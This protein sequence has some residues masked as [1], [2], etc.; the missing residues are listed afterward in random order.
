MH[1]LS[2]NLFQNTNSLSNNIFNFLYK[3]FFF[4]N[5]NNYT[6]YLK[7]GY[8]KIGCIDDKYITDIIS[9]LNVQAKNI[10]AP[11]FKLKKSRNTIISIK[12]IINNCL[13]D[14]LKNLENIFNASIKFSFSEITRNYHVDTKKEYYS[15]YLHTDG[16]NCLLQKIFIN[17]D[18]VNENQGPLNILKYPISKKTKKKL[19]ENNYRLHDDKIKIDEELFFI[20]TGKK[21]S[22]LI[23]DST[24]VLHKAGIPKKNNHRDMLLLEF[25][26]VPKDNANSFYLDENKNDLDF[27][28]RDD[29][30]FSKSEA[31]LKSKFEL[32]KK[33]LKIII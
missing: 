10:D 16:Y 14:H 21:G 11:N 28:L 27:Y 29:N 26:I 19:I 23:V 22:V 1:K 4:K 13:K 32:I 3:K 24:N 15:N 20:N 31:K 25:V 2:V 17:L 8:Q 18:N 12:K 6:H 33:F 30:I 7:N 9:D 5:N